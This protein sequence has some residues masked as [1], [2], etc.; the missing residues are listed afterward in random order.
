MQFE[1]AN[2]DYEELLKWI[3]EPPQLLP[4]RKQLLTASLPLA[5]ASTAA[6]LYF[7]YHF[8]FHLRDLSGGHILSD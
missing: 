1:S 7:L 5:A 3:E 6:L 4:S 8:F 2:S